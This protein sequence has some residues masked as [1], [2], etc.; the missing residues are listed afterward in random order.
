MTNN[1]A[2]TSDYEYVGDSGAGGSN[3]V[4]VFT[5]FNGSN[6]IDDNLEIGVNATDTGTYNLSGNCALSVAGTGYVGS[7]GMG[8][9]TLNGGSATFSGSDIR[10][11]GLSIGDQPS[12]QGVFNLNFGTL[13]VAAS[14]SVGYNASAFNQTGGTNTVGSDFGIGSEAVYNLYGG[15]FSVSGEESV[16]GTFNQ[17]GGTNTAGG[18]VTI[19][20]GYNL[21]GGSLSAAGGES[22]GSLETGTINQTGGTNSSP[23]LTVGVI[24]GVFGDYFLS[25]GTLEVNG[26]A[27]S[28]VLGVQGA[29]A[30][31]SN[32]AEGIFY[33][34]GGANITDQ[35][36]LGLGTDTRFNYSAFGEYYLIGGSLSAGQEQLGVNGLALFNQTGGTNTTTGVMVLHEG[37]YNLSGGILS[38]GA[39]FVRPNSSQFNWTGGT[40]EITAYFGAD[41]QSIAVPATGELVFEPNNTEVSTLSGLSIAPGGIVDLG[42]N[43]L[44]IDYGNG[45]DPIASIAQWIANGFYNLPGP[46]IISSAIAS[47]DAASGLSYGIGYA[48]GADG[49]VAGLP[50]G[51]IEI[52]FTLLGDANLDGTVNAEDY[53]TFS[54]NLGLTGMYWDDGDFNYDGTVNAEDYTL[55][56]QNIGQSAALA[57]IDGAPESANGINLANVPEPMSAGVIVMAGLE[58]LTRRRRSS[59]RPTL[60]LTSRD[61]RSC[62]S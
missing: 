40:L 35:L 45:P 18:E 5:Q 15:S 20:V 42:N 12:G 4:G 1:D 47:A 13:N 33:Q 60:G 39:L 61:S 21:N 37:T 23:S 52:M 25:G 56:S 7:S 36:V 44:I 62:D 26:G 29:V 55:F 53:T 43:T 30:P 10:G 3:G 41:L 32:G 48:D 16:A 58:M 27:D 38:V 6:T 11:D 31:E 34:T 50:S 9:F 49:I 46:K 2:L 17:T 19:G 24:P 54:Q 51:E 14:E 28:E 8:S 22:V 57:A 59:R